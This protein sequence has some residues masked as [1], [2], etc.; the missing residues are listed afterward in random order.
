MIPTYDINY[1]T[2][3][4]KMTLIDRYKQYK[5][6]SNTHNVESKTINSKYIELSIEYFTKSDKII[7]KSCTGTGKTT[8]TAETIKEYN[9]NLRKPKSILSIISKISINKVGIK[10]SNYLDKSTK[11]FVALIQLCS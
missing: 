4:L 5:M 1:L 2:H 6:L 10:L 9:S 3:I 7:M 8:T 11:L